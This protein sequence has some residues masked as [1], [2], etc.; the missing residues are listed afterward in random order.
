MASRYFL[1]MVCA[2]ACASLRFAHS[3][4]AAAPAKLS[5]N[6]DIRPI[7]SENCFA[8]HGFD[9]KKREA[10]LRLDTAEGALAPRDVGPAIKPSDPEASEVWRR[11][12]S[13]DPDVVMPPPASHKSL[14]P[15]QKEILRR[16]I[17]EG[18]AYQKH[19]AFER[20]VAVEP[21]QVDDA[22]W[23]TNPI[24]RFIRE[25]LQAENL[26]PQPEADRPTLIRRVAFALTGLP[27]TIAQVDQFLADKSPAAYEKMVERYLASPRYGEEMARHWLDV[28]RYADT[29]GLHLDN[30][31]TMYAYRDWVI[32][33][34]NENLP[35]DDFTVWQLAGDQLPNPTNDQLTATGFNRCNVTTSEGGS[36]AEEFLYRYAVDRAS[37]TMQT[38]MGLTGGCA[39]CHDHKY[40]PLTQKE[41]YSFYSFF[42]DAAD[43]AMDGNITTTAPFTK[44]PTA[45]QKQSLEA[46]TKAKADAAKNLEAV[47]AAAK[48]EEPAVAKSQAVPIRNVIFDDD[49]PL[50]TTQR[51]TSRNASTW[52]D[53]PDFGAKSGRRVLHQANARFHQEIL[54]VGL[55]TLVVPET[56]GKFEI[57]VRPDPLQPPTAVS[58]LFDSRRAWWGEESAIDAGIPGLT[59]E[60]R[61]GPLPKPGEWT[62]LEVAAVDVGLKPGTH[63]KT[64]TVQES[65]GV[66]SWDA[67]AMT[68]VTEPAAD[69]LVSFDHWRETVGDVAPPEIPGSLTKFFS[70]K[71]AVRKRGVKPEP[72]SAK[73]AAEPN[74]LSEEDFQPLRDF[75]VAYVMREPPT[76]VAS[77]RAVW[78]E[79]R[80]A[81][82]VVDDAVVG[83]MTY[84]DVPQPRDAFVMMRGQY[85]QPGEKVEPTVPAI[86]PALQKS[87]ADQR[88]RR[89]DLARWLVA[90]EHPLTARMQVNRLWQQ[91]FGVGL[92]KT[93]E[94]FGSQGEP[95]SHPELLDWLAVDFQKHGWDTKR[96][97]RQLV[98][99]QAFRQ[100]SFAAPELRARDPENRLLARGP[101]FRL[102]AEQIRDNALFVSGLINLRMGGEGVKSYQPPNIWEPVGYADSNTRY[103]LQD[104]GDA[105]YRRSIY[106]FL[107]RT[108]PPPF[109]SNF[110][111]PNREQMCSRRERS[112]TPLQAL[113]LM[114]DVQHFEAARALA[115]RALAEGGKSDAERIAYLYRTVLSRSPDDRELLVVRRA[116][117]EQRRLYANDERAAAG[118][119]RVGESKPAGVASAEETAAW[120]L[121]ANLVLNL[122]ETLNRN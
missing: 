71:P 104:H 80:L 25:R 53:R 76:N 43:P 84:A 75:Y 32:R 5:F 37:T 22:A 16:W 12:V 111:G 2:A 36:I 73:S 15:E 74:E 29:H 6:R 67:F 7:L 50:G 78:I 92:V 39:V 63:I 99:S 108:A 102:D 98:M 95:P 121:T 52:I 101:R 112:N 61:R 85:D 19:W 68:G 100:Q 62:K 59:P 40:D 107:K 30:E 64:V 13:D 55:R 65:G 90:P 26:T 56:D 9:S 11:I 87:S 58:L 110:D 89:L 33:A 83:T 38:W 54:T 4:E 117:D 77:A 46:A 1:W 86:F 24:D 94:D 14:K 93:S 17:A 57:W 8:C 113:Q 42:Y 45:E 28:A 10:D 18:A 114:N 47:V 116:L 109:M 69:P 20:P 72:K 34:L 97:V 118:A 119:I 41:F 35:F 51:N 120:T 79:A 70:K 96:F 122:D 48:Y 91:F 106:A 44:L 105:L 31:R 66:V 27:P 81:E 3:A 60:S 82:A 49:Y 88:L 103:Y 21:P 23:S 115:E